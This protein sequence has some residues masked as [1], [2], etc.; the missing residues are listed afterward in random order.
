MASLRA[1][2]LS[3]IPD[4]VFQER[5]RFHLVAAVLSLPCSP[6]RTRKKKDCF[7][8]VVAHLALLGLLSVARK[9]LP[10]RPLAVILPLL[11]LQHRYFALMIMKSSLL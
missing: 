4:V 6:V 1:L 2:D 10:P 8:I 11:Y 9:L 5:L 7:G 3:R